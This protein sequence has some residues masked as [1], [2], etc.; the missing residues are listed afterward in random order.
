M[1]SFTFFRNNKPT[2]IPTMEDKIN[3]HALLKFTCDQ[4]LI[5]IEIA[6]VVPIKATRGV[7]VFMSVRIA[8]MGMA[9]IAS[10]NPKVDLQRLE[11]KIIPRITKKTISMKSSLSVHCKNSKV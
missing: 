6:I 5:R 11:K 2:G 1:S 10:P 9:I 4:C 3:L 7:A 8:S